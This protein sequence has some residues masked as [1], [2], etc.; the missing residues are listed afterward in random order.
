MN[1]WTNQVIMLLINN[2]FTLP[3]HFHI[4]ITEGGNSPR[5]E[6]VEVS[7]EWRLLVV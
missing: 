1:I 3:G 4:H 5:D 7:W 6:Q 2:F